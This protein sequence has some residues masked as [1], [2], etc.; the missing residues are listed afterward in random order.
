V[1]VCVEECESST[2]APCEFHPCFLSCK[3]VHCGVLI[4]LV[5]FHPTS[6]QLT[7]F[8]RNWVHCDWSHLGKLG[9]ALWSGCNQS[10]STNL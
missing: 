6:L 5:S 3:I 1:C 9:L 8:H 4:T 10:Q 2:L 7:L